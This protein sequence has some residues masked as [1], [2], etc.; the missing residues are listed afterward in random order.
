M[1]TSMYDVGCEFGDPKSA[2]QTDFRGQK[3]ATI[4]A[5]GVVSLLLRPTRSASA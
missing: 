5:G 1:M 4:I 3:S 2:L